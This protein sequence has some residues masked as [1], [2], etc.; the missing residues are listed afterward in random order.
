MTLLLVGTL[1][2]VASLVLLG[3]LRASVHVDTVHTWIPLFLHT[4][5]VIGADTCVLVLVKL[6]SVLL[7]TA[8]PR[9]R[10]FGSLT[11]ATAGADMLKC[12]VGPTAVGLTVSESSFK[13]D[14]CGLPL[15]WTLTVT[16]NGP[17]AVGVPESTPVVGFMVRPLGWPDTDHAYGVV[18]PEAVIATAA[19]VVPSVAVAGLSPVLVIDSATVAELTVSEKPFKED[20]CGLLL[21]WTVTIRLNVPEAVGVPER[22]PV[23]GLTVTPLGWPETDHVYGIVPPVAVTACAA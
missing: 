10:V 14:C 5:L 23:V 16:V 2:Q 6:T 22:T 8:M 13:V 19:Y 17:E 4:K 1:L 20:C 15:S 11:V 18:P 9:F 12:A 7:P 21:S 3:V